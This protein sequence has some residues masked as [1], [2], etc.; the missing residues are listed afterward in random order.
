MA[1]DDDIK[2]QMME[3]IKL[4]SP[5]QLAEVNE[6][7]LDA[8]VSAARGEPSNFAINETVYVSQEDAQRICTKIGL[9]WETGK[10]R[11]EQ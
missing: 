7:I 1:K 5:E 6:A 9:N 11:P 10:M 8:L 3:M 4:L 2:Q